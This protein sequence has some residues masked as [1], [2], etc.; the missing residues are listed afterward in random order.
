MDSREAEVIDCDRKPLEVNA[1]RR[2]H[3]NESR[4]EAKEKLLQWSRA[5]AAVARV[6]LVVVKRSD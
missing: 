1:L 4:R 2:T 6:P 5:E 3:W